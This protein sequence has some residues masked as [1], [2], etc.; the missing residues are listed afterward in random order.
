M[1]RRR[2]ASCTVNLS[3]TVK[4]TRSDGG[5]NRRVKVTGVR[6]RMLRVVLTYKAWVVWALGVKDG[7]VSKC[8]IRGVLGRAVGQHG[9]CPLGGC[10]TSS[11]GCSRRK[12]GRGST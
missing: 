9:G 4:C 7:A 5:I 3:M 10:H 8:V 12:K 6:S 1:P 11:D 2:A